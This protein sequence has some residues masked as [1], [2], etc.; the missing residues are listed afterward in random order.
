MSGLLF[1]MA[2]HVQLA[3]LEHGLQ[4]GGNVLVMLR[5]FGFRLAGRAKLL[6]QKFQYPAVCFPVQQGLVVCENR[7]DIGAIVLEF[8]ELLH[9]V[10]IPPRV[11]IRRQSHHLVFIQSH[12]K[13]QIQCKDPIKNSQRVERGNLFD[14]LN[15][16]PVAHRHRHAVDLSHA[17]ADQNQRVAKSTGIKSACG[18]GQMMVHRHE[19]IFP[20]E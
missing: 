3:V 9:L 8:D 6:L 7:D 15:F 18:M 17:I 13:T 10:V 19:L 14:N 12:V 16:C 2:Q 5:D 1:E 11:A 4:R 20:V